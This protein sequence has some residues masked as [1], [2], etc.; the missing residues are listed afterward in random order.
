MKKRLSR[1][2]RL[3][4]L[5]TLLC[6]ATLSAQ[7]NF[8]SFITGI[9]TRTP[10]LHRVSFL[11]Q[12]NLAQNTQWITHI[13]THNI[14]AAGTTPLPNTLVFNL[15][16]LPQTIGVNSILPRLHPA[17]LPLK[18][19]SIHH[20]NCGADY[21][22]E[23]DFGINDPTYSNP[24]RH[25]FQA[26][27]AVNSGFLT[28]LQQGCMFNHLGQNPV[29]THNTL[30]VLGSIASSSGSG[31]TPAELLWDRKLDFRDGLTAQHRQHLLAR[32]AQIPHNAYY[33]T[34]DGTTESNLSPAVQIFHGQN[35]TGQI[36]F[37]N[38]GML[39]DGLA[40]ITTAGLHTPIAVHNNIIYSL[41]SYSMTVFMRWFGQVNNE[42]SLR[43]FIDEPE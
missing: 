19:I 32:E 14:P 8:W 29:T 2:L 36:A 18:K 9:L 37:I 7:A 43:P 23:V 3:S 26:I 10:E 28:A 30:G 25:S 34:A 15:Y 35:G 11:L 6:L 40:I 27:G 4:T 5:F 24:H 42:D 22:V 39:T 1:T 38:P 41:F 21:H 33:F 20:K 31:N 17:I 13:V 12:T 16:S